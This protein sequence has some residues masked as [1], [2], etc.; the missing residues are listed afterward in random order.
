MARRKLRFHR[1]NEMRAAGEHFA[2]LLDRLGDGREGRLIR[3]WQNWDMVMGPELAELAWPLGARKSILLVGGEDNLTLQ[4]LS[5]MTPEIL[6]RVNAFM[7]TD[8]PAFDKVDLQLLMGRKSM[9]QRVRMPGEPPAGTQL[10]QKKRPLPEKPANLGGPLREMRA[11]SPV[12]IAY[13]AYLKMFG[14]PADFEK[15]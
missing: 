3:L 9:D 4:D 6:E 12:T 5:F 1:T 15:C 10:W 2:S 13:L 11:D 14:L 7:G 8:E